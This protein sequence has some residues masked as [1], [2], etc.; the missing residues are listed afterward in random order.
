[1]RV[2]YLSISIRGTPL[3]QYAY[4]SATNPNVVIRVL[5][6]RLSEA[7]AAQDVPENSSVKIIRE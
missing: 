3:S 6:L 7:T 2:A 1:M 4:I 5:L